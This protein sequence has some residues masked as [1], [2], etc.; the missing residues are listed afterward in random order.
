[1]KKSLFLFALGLVTF[2][3]AHAQWNSWNTSSTISGVFG[4]INHGIESAERKK[5][6][7]IH[8]KEKAQYEQSFKDAMESARDYEGGEYW[9]DALTKYEEVAKLNCKYGYTDQMQITRKIN[10]LYVK[11]GRKEDGPS[12][13]NNNTTILAD[14]SKYRYVRENPVYVNK[15]STS[16]KIVRVACSDTETRLEMEFLGSYVN[17]GA[18][19]KGTTYIKG[20]K[21]GK[22]S[23]EGVENI[24][25]APNSTRTPWPGQKLRFVLIFPALPDNATEFDLIEPSTDWKFKDIKCK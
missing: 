25:M 24:T 19:I 12:I 10:D 23:L 5:Q 9:D 16:T 22:L 7:E 8:A 11:A 13:L 14:Y 15:K 6:M 21:G 20:N 1:M 2:M 17:D 3:P 4:A 18:S